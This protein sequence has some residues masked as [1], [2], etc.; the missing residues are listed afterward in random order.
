MI[1][2]WQGIAEDLQKVN[3]D[4]GKYGLFYADKENYMTC[5]LCPVR[6]SCIYP[7][8]NTQ[9]LKNS[10]SDYLLENKLSALLE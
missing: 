2:D 7:E 3:F 5:N 9:G 1:L 6:E 10:L 4:C 8:T